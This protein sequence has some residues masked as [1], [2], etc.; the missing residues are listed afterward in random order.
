MIGANDDEGEV[1]K[2]VGWRHLPRI[3][4]ADWTITAA[5]FDANEALAIPYL[6]QTA[7]APLSRQAREGRAWAYRF[8]EHP[9]NHLTAGSLIVQFHV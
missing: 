7:Q 9:R 6:R 3:W 5:S 2:P 1:R 4:P 8:P